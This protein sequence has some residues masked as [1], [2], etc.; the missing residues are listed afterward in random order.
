MGGRE[1]G[2]KDEQD[3]TPEVPCQREQQSGHSRP[4][5][6][7]THGNRVRLPSR[8]IPGWGQGWDLVEAPMRGSA[9]VETPIGKGQTLAE[10]SQGQVQSGAP[11]RRRGSRRGSLGRMHR[12]GQLCREG[13]H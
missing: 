13:G 5:S 10:S 1:R 9:E 3:S 12:T 11:S 4:R 2:V 7:V 8:R 6:A